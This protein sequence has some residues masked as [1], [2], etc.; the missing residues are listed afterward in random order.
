M[1]PQMPDLVLTTEDLF[2]AFV[3]G[4]LIGLER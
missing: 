3:L 1:T 4:A 2:L